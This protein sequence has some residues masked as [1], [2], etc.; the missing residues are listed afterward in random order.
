M[1]LIKVGDLRKENN[2]KCKYVYKLIHEGKIKMYEQDGYTYYDEDE[3]QE[4]YAT[5]RVGRPF[6]SKNKIKEV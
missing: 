1:K 5:S 4:H 2:A 6:G 3:L